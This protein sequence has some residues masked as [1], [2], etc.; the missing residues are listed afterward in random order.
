MIALSTSTLKDVSD[1]IRMHF[2]AAFVR[3]I[4]AYALSDLR[5]RTLEVQKHE[6]HNIIE[7]ANTKYGVPTLHVV[8]GDRDA[9]ECLNISDVREIDYLDAAR[10]PRS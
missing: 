1:L 3:Q 6:A 10:Q 4:Q 2:A 9:I 7:E 8:P 5:V